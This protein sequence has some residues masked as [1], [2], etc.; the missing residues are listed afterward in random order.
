MYATLNGARVFFDIDGAGLRWQDGT[1]GVE[2]PTLVLLPGGPAA[3][4]LHYKR[5]MA[6]FLRY[7]TQFQI[8]YVDWRGAGNS[9]P[10]PPETMTLR[11]AV[12]DVEALREHLGIEQWTVLGAS[13]GGPW[14]LQYAATYPERVTRVVAM[15]C[16][17]DFEGM[18]DWAVRNAKRAGVTDPRALDLYSRFGGG[19]L[20]E[21]VEEWAAVVRDTIIR[22]QQATYIDPEKHPEAVKDHQQRW[23]S[24][25]E[26][27][28]LDELDASRWYLNDFRRNYPTSE[29][30]GR[31]TAPTLVMTGEADPVAPPEHARRI[32]AAITGS[33]LY[34]HAGAH[35]PHGDEQEPFFERLDKFF[36]DH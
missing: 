21:P 1:L 31:V 32:A 22:T 16:P 12:D 27:K 26:R 35:M 28:L 2:Y 4:H 7:T 20:T 36:A 34:L 30:Y 13:A 8:V 3:S 6:G 23:D 15:H 9:L 24:V 25:P 17:A 18:S 29:T 14:A 10:A 5:P 11:Q 33:E 19:E